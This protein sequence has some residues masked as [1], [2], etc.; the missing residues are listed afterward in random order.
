MAGGLAEA[1][2]ARRLQGAGRPEGSAIG[3][4]Q[5][6]GIGSGLPALLKQ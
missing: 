2:I 4:E 1:E 3:A 6:Q 5:E